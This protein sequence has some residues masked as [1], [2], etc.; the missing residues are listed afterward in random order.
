M[1]ERLIGGLFTCAK[2]GQARR[3]QDTAPSVGK[4]MRLFG[5]TIAA[6]DMAEETGAD[7]LVLIDEVV[8]WHRSM[9]A[10][11][12]VDALADLAQEDTLLLATERY[13]TL[14]RFSGNFLDTFTFKAS[15]SGTNPLS[16]IDLLKQTNASRGAHLRENPPMPFANQQ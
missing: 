6:L 4:L 13:A 7:P 16:A 5:A 1:F 2:R 11:P 3:Y 14:R 12:H 15:S 10:R 9:T 8:G